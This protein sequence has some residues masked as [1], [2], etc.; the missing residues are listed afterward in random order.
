MKKIIL[1]GLFALLLLSGY[2]QPNPQ[3]RPPPPP[4]ED[5]EIENKRDPQEGRF[6]RGDSKQQKE[7]IELFKIQY[8]TKK[9]DLTKTEAE[10]FW[11]VYE[12]HKKAVTEILKTK[13]EDEIIFQEAMLNARKKYKSDLK[14]VLKSDERVNNALKLERDFLR[15]MHFEM[16]RRRGL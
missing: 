4:R 1:S 16:N 2:T 12:E 3:R 11:P 8:I 5:Q 6:K 13:S 10:T 7:R 14:P 15:K 9:L